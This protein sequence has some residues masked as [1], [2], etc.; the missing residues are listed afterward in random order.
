MHRSDTYIKM[1]KFWGSA[2]WKVKR[3]ELDGLG[4]MRVPEVVFP[5]LHA[6]P[7]LSE[8][9]EEEESEGRKRRERQDAREKKKLEV[10]IAEY[11]VWRDCIALH[12]NL[13]I[14]VSGEYRHFQPFSTGSPDIRKVK[15]GKNQINRR[16]G[17]M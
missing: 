10:G 11:Q 13:L 15:K 6:I 7:N 14:L 5:E 1:I 9:W 4:Q 16:P 2:C 17:K 12:G 3:S 8:K